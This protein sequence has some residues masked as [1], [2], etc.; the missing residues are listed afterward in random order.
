MV[1][2]ATSTPTREGSKIVST[3]LS[4]NINISSSRKKQQGV[5]Y[6]NSEQTIRCHTFHYI[7]DLYGLQSSGSDC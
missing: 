2:L 6:Q 1:D 5:A 7:I 3:V 4:Y